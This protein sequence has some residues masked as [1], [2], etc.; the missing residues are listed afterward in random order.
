MARAVSVTAPN[1]LGREEGLHF[2][3]VPPYLRGAGEESR[4][5]GGGGGEIKT[6]E[7]GRREER[8][9]GLGCSVISQTLITLFNQ[10]CL[11]GGSQGPS[12]GEGCDLT[13]P[14]AAKGDRYG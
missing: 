3:R 7:E 9:W 4:R 13:P 5:E 1:F 8:D 12:Q 2:G 10:D 11:C 6:R 14:H